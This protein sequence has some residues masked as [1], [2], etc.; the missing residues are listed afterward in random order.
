LA[1][2]VINGPLLFEHCNKFWFRGRR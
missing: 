1:G 2:S